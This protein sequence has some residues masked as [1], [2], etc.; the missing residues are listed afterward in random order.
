VRA[1]VP[2][3]EHDGDEADKHDREKPSLL[4]AE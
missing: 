1:E 3:R 4:D 2:P